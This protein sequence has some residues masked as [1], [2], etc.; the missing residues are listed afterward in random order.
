MGKSSPNV[1]FVSPR[2]NPN[3]FWSFRATAEL[4]GARWLAPPLGLITVAA[5]LPQTWK[6]KLID[7]NVAA[8]TDK[9]LAA[10]DL[11]MTGGMLPQEPDMLDIIQRCARVGT[12]VCVGGSAP[13]STPDVYAHADFLVVGE[14]EGIIGDFVAAWERGDKRGRFDAEKFK[15]D[16]TSTPVPRFDLLTYGKYLWINVQFSRGCPFTCE[17]CDVIELFGRAPRTKT[18]PQMLGELDRLHASGYRGHVDFVDDNLIGNKKAIKAFLP[19]LRKWQEDR[20]YPFKFTT[21]ASLNLAD[22]AE[23]L[24]MMRA[25]RFFALFTG[26]ESPDEATLVQMQK[27]Q[28]TRRSIADSVHRIVD[29]GMYVSGGFII[30]FDEEKQRTAP[31]MIACI[32]DAD[33]PAAMVG[34]LTALPNT[35]LQR[36]L[37]REGRLFDAFRQTMATSG[38]HSMAGLNFATLRPRREIYQDLRDVVE[39]VYRPEAY[40]QRV[41]RLSRRLKPARFPGQKIHLRPMLVDAL[42]F[43]R[44]A[45][46]MTVRHREVRPHFW[47]AIY[48]GLR[49]DWRS[50]EVLGRHGALYA[51]LY[52]YAQTLIRYLD[53]RLAEM[54]Q[55]EP[56]VEAEAAGPVAALA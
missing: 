44:L 52:P 4:R 31:G 35:Q 5:M 26:I 12:P 45:W 28:N 32:D 21:E 11:V 37:M 38:D 7:Q 46:V 22:D 50:L 18:T 47:A 49:R 14:A 33:I 17:F 29:A 48:E 13:T 23:L 9:D 8:L 10:A 39:T 54:A 42:G 15:A 20:G 19:H 27:K 53:D 43:A 1:L 41:R 56:V 30:G 51:H 2:F 36:R 16:V 6:I 3:S 24:G 40:F 34:L 25:A 55:E